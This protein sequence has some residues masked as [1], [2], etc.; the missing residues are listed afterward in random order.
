MLPVSYLYHL[1]ENLI[2]KLRNAVL[3]RMIL[4]LT[5]IYIAVSAVTEHIHSCKS[6]FE[7]ERN[8]LVLECEVNQA[9]MNTSISIGQV[10]PADG[11]RLV[12]LVGF[13]DGCHQ[14][15]ELFSSLWQP[16]LVRYPCIYKAH[17][18][19]SHNKSSAMRQ[20]EHVNAIRICIDNVHGT[21]TFIY[22][23]SV[24]LYAIKSAEI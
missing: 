17:T 20:F 2:T 13:L 14:F 5:S 9:M 23:S 10:K 12:L 8:M 18:I 6:C 15:V 7:A 24:M 1:H 16:V 19:P 11:D 21:A 3:S 22:L 4:S